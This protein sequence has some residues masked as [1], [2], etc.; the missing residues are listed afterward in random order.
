MLLA[1]QQESLPPPG[2]EGGVVTLWPSDG[3]EAMV[4][5]GETMRQ[6]DESMKSLAF[7]GAYVRFPLADG[8]LVVRSPNGIYQHGQDE[9]LVFKD[10]VHMSH[11]HSRGVNVA[12]AEYGAVLRNG[13]LLFRN[14]KLQ[15]GGRLVE[16]EQVILT[17]TNQQGTFT[18][19]QGAG[20][21]ASEPGHILWVGALAALPP[22][23][24]VAKSPPPPPVRGQAIP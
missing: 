13:S 22:S 8:A 2:A 10:P 3:G 1:C 18:E 5:H 11:A 15:S 6:L 20:Q 12:R 21:Y 16:H 4:V 14:M 9:E 23:A 7:D 19:L 24:F 17:G